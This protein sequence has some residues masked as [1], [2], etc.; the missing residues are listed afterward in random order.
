MKI[1]NNFYNLFFYQKPWISLFAILVG[2]FILRLPTLFVEYYDIDLLTSFMGAKNA[3]GGFPVSNNKGPLYQWVLNFSFSFFG[4]GGGSFHFIGII[5]IIATSLALYFMGSTLFCKKSG[6]I[7]ALLYGFCISAFNRQFMAINGEIVYNLFFVLGFLFFYHLVFLKK[8]VY[9]F[10]LIAVL[11]GAALTKFQGIW[12]VLALFIFIIFV[13]PAYKMS[14]PLLKK[15]YYQIL[16]LFVFLVLVFIFVDWFYTQFLFSEDGFL[17]DQF[18]NLYNYAAVRGFSWLFPIKLLHR[19]GMLVVYHFPLWI[20]AFFTLYS[21]FKKN[22]K[23]FKLAY[24]AT[25]LFFIFS[26]IFL[27]GDRLYFHYFVQLY[28]LLALLAAP[29]IKEVILEKKNFQKA[30]F[31]SFMIPVFFIF[32]WNTKD[33][34]ITRLKPSFF[35]NEPK[36]LEIFRLAF[37]G[38]EKDYLLP[39]KVYLPFLDILKKEAKPQETILVWPVGAEVTYFSGLYSAVPNYWHEYEPIRILKGAKK[40]KTED[41]KVLEQKM[42]AWI[43]EANPHYFMDISLSPVVYFRQYGSLSD[44]FKEVRHYLDQNWFLLKEENGL[45]LWKKKE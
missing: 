42:I 33:T 2:I 29:K 10:P 9:F 39:H 3:L 36:T 34:L 24:L 12:A 22:K 13:F 45:M 40:G 32:V 26:T 38:Q 20:G 27:T 17:R 1:Q 41:L 37:L 25:L 18:L 30:F 35:Y 7:A 43:K 19:V 4:V 14:S 6:I 31:L 11:I 16:T 23:D 8:W 21:F 28:P 15:K 44:N 5:I